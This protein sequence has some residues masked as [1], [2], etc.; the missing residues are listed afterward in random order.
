MIS[1]PI[2]DAD[3]NKSAAV[4]R[5]AFFLLPLLGLYLAVVFVA[6]TNAFEGDEGGYVENAS[7]IVHW[8]A[9]SAQDH[10]LWWGP[11]YSLVLIPF[12]ALHLPW[13]AAK[14]LNAGFLFAA[15]LY[16]YGL[17]RRY[18]AAGVAF[19]PALALGLY[20]PF[21]R[22][23]HHLFTE[24]LVFLLICGFMFHFCALFT[25]ASHF[26]LHLIAASMF[27]G[28]LA[29]TKV[30]FGYVIVTSIVLSFGAYLWR[31]TP[32][33]RTTFL[34]FLLGLLFCVPFLTYTRAITGRN[35]YWGTSGGMSL[36]WLS[37]PYPG[38]LGS[39]FS[40][41]QVDERD[42]LAPH[43]DFF[44]RLEGLSD[45]ERDDAFKK[46][47]LYN[48][49]HYPGKFARNC[50]ANV[51]RLLFS[52]PFSFGSDRL[53][54]FFYLAPNMFV[55]VLFLLS[56]VP[57]AVRPRAV[58]F[59]LWVLLVFAL[60]AF[61]GSTL[62]SAYDRQFRPLVPILCAFS[63]FVYFR[64]LKIDFRMGDQVPAMRTDS[65]VF[66]SHLYAANGNGNFIAEEVKGVVSHA[67]NQ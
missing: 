58:P 40:V 48:I 22:E 19:I 15:I 57:A 3:G 10:H 26:R 41:K 7:R 54:T 9:A 52:Y 17:M 27:L 63:A 43:R 49:S 42:E 38:E 37:S 47:A 53:S 21:L 46:Q 13:I 34:V 24:S 29:L 64:L 35:F 31:R 25:R 51:G 18:M 44:A 50:A 33:L 32:A 4:P 20:P 30:F 5:P 39:W 14:C 16:F 8:Q 2:V 65:A 36:Y 67:A 66:E 23:V 61:S 11:G 45:I 62:L 59:E 55:V 12:V 60:V 6:S 28:Y 56:L 1:N